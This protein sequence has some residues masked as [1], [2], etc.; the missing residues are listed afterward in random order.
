MFTL[1]KILLASS[2]LA[3][4]TI[5]NFS[6]ASESDLSKA[7]AVEGSLKLVMQGLLADTQQL[8]TAMLVEDFANIEK[9]AKNIADH[10]KASLATRMKLMKAMG[11]EMAR[12]KANDMVVHNAAVNMT[13][14]AQQKNIQG[15]TDDF[16]TMIGGC[17]SC[18]SEF[19]AK[20]SAMF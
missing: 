7:S 8:T 11:T 14:N 13:K 9:S 16:K 17:V 15:I 10:P 6:I 19:K 18:H 12:F 3:F 4:T 2:I 1:K 5:V 20:V